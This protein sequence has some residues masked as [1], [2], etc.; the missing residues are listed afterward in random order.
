LSK[1]LKPKPKLA[2][3][4]RK[5]PPRWQR[6]K[7]IS[8]VIWIVVPL[9][10]AAVLGLVGYWTYNNYVAAWGQPVLQ[11]NEKTFDMD[12]LVK[13]LRFYSGTQT[14]SGQ[15]PS[16]YQVLNTI[17]QQELTRQGAPA[18]GLEA[19]PDEVNQ[20]TRRFLG[21][22]AA[23]NSTEPAGQFEETYQLLL[24]TTGLSDQECRDVFRGIVLAGNITTYLKDTEVPTEAEQVHLQMIVVADEPTVQ[25]LQDRIQQ[26]E[27]FSTLAEQYGTIEEL[28]QAAGNLGWVPKGIYPELDDVAFTLALGNVSG[29]IQ[30][31]RGFCLV[32][33]LDK[34]DN[35][36]IE[37]TYRDILATNALQQW[38]DQE[39]AASDIKQYLDQ[40]KATWATN[41]I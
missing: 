13:M 24:D 12:Y 17:E 6:E 37:D 20:A 27:D 4:S 28:K 30:T 2:V 41:H 3:A 40:D 18:L 34:A 1:K 25:E 14:E 23:G 10:I 32:K 16:A 7:N 22:A 33:V 29:P 35:M 36:P 38:L 11:V 21:L 39:K 5:Q 26:G 15:T 31:D 8:L 19:T 9:I